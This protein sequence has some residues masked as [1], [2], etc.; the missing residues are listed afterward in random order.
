MEESFSTGSAD[1]GYV[2]SSQSH[3]GGN[4]VGSNTGTNSKV[5]IKNCYSSGYV[6]SQSSG[7]GGYKSL[8]LDYTQFGNCVRDIEGVYVSGRIYDITDV[9]L[10]STVSTTHMFRGGGGLKSQYLFGENSTINENF[11][12]KNSY[13]LYGGEW[14]DAL[15]TEA[16][17]STDAYE[18]RYPGRPW[19]LKWEPY[20]NPNE[21]IEIN[22]EWVDSN[23]YPYYLNKN[24]K[25]VEDISFSW[26]DQFFIFCEEGL[27]F[28]GCGNKITILINNYRGAFNNGTYNASND[29]Y[30]GETKIHDYRLNFNYKSGYSYITI[31]NV[32]VVV[33]IE[34]NYYVYNDNG[35]ICQAGYGIGSRGLLIENCYTNGRTSNNYTGGICGSYTSMVGSELTLKKCYSLRDIKDGGLISGRN[36]NDATSTIKMID[37]R[38]YGDIYGDNGGG[39]IGY[40]LRW[41]GYKEL[42]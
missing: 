3:R 20:I 31:K 41:D 37:C 2:L 25:L 32:G 13:D 15:A 6:G 39:L 11:P 35:W 38:T 18:N 10:T 12:I 9:S 8:T 4:L 30:H 33:P 40:N 19:K 21:Y 17:L 36:T 23:S 27:T 5:V 1:I 29:V 26:Q 28:D 24:A 16:G 34:F 22:Q 7:V 42:F 14:S